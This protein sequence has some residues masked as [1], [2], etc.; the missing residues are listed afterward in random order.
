MYVLQVPVE[1]HETNLN[2]AYAEYMAIIG[3]AKECC[4]KWMYSVYV[5]VY[6]P[7]VSA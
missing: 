6:A 5:H 7:R 4:K 1:Q 2:A 3:D